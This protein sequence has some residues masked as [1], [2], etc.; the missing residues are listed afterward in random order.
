[1]AEWRDRRRL[2]KHEPQIAGHPQW[3]SRGYIPHFDEEGLTQTLTFRLFDSMPQEVLDSWRDELRLVPAREAN[4]E[5]RERI[6]A[7]LDLGHGSCYL[8]DERLA[9]IVQ[10]ALLHFDNRRYRLHAWVVM[11]NHVHTLYTAEPGWE[12]SQIAHSWKSYTANECNRV[13]KRKGEFWPREPFDRYIRNSEAFRECVA[14]Y[15]G[16]SVKGGVVRDA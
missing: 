16:E 8:R 14:L 1:M 12:L 10:N 5:R 7:Y 2:A 9:N 11:P 15:R 4:R 6:D 13:L 3:Y